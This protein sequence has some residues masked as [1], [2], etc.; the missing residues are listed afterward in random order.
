MKKVFDLKFMPWVM[1]FALTIGYGLAIKIPFPWMV[2]SVPT[3]IC[4]VYLI[5]LTYFQLKEKKKYIFSNGLKFEYAFIILIYIYI[6]YSLVIY[7]VNSLQF[8]FLRNILTIYGCMAFVGGIIYLADKD[9]F[10]R[11]HRAFFKYIILILILYSLFYDFSGSLV[12]FASFYILF[13]RFIPANRRW[14]IIGALLV[15]FFFP[16]QRMPLLRV[17]LIGIIYILYHFKYLTGILLHIMFGTLMM[18]PAFFFVL[19]LTGKYSVFEEMS[20]DKS[21]SYGN[22]ALMEDTRTLLF[23][24]ALLSSINNDYMWLGRSFSR[25]YDSE[26]QT[27]RAE[28]NETGATYD[29]TERNS[30]VFIVNIYTWM[31]VT[32]VALFF[33]LFIRAGYFAI[34]K[35]KNKYMKLIGLCV[36]VQW[37]FCWIE[38]CNVTVTEEIF[39]LWTMVAMCLSPYWR[40]LSDR[41]F[42]KAI[43]S[44]FNY[45]LR[46]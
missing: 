12:T 43:R 39:I 19:A 40:G 13:W 8:D 46:S 31:G 7:F 44:A 34:Y 32:G 2:I 42:E 3:A 15:L 26:F 37:I 14:L 20:E 38:N 16:G 36:A 6:A 17:G 9:V 45:K 35:S 28:K 25:G 29:I 10:N 33:I 24:E 30:E 11:V 5:G 4:S 1:F 18:L 22:E 27:G 23:Q 21:L 41:E